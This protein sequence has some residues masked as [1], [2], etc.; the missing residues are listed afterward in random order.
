MRLGAFLVDGLILSAV[1]WLITVI[2][3]AFGFAIDQ[4][5]FGEGAEVFSYS[6]AGHGVIW[7]VIWIIGI[8]IEVMYFVAFWAWKGQTPGK[9]ALGIKIIRTDGSS[10]SWGR[11]F[12]R[13]LDY[14]ISVITIY[15]GFTWI[16]FDGRRQGLHDKVADTYV[17]R[18]PRKQAILPETYS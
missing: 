4:T 6:A 14:I 7:L 2:F 12:L 18:L 9:I 11:A 16:V 15:I 5:I 10:L 3:V 17:V 8:A 13:Y 1:G